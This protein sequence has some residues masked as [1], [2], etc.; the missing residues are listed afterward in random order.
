[1]EFTILG[2]GS[3]ANSYFFKGEDAT[4]L[5]DCGYTLP[6]WERR[7]E[8]IS[9][10]GD[11]IDFILTTH[12]HSDHIKGIQRI[13]QKYQ[14]PVY[15]ERNFPSMNLYERKEFV[16]K[17]SFD[18][19][20]VQFYPFPTMH[21][22]LNSAGFY[23]CVDEIR[24]ALITDTGILTEEMFR[25]ALKSHVLF[26]EANYCEELLP[27]C[28]YP[29]FLKDRIGGVSGHLS[30]QMAFSFLSQL[31][32]NPQSLIKKVYL[33]HLSEESNDF[34]RVKELFSPLENRGV[35]ITV[36]PKNQLIKGVIY[37]SL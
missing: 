11:S 30:N 29:Q 21:D 10:K 6:Q 32:E 23:F 26:L 36:C 9:Q 8:E 13:S 34:S 12:H 17:K 20:G 15:V 19:Q 2:S 14:I 1:M 22:A 33:C 31:L 28:R 27:Y 4:F 25:L 16:L 5:I 18:V 3:T 35:A 7:M 37:D 24:F